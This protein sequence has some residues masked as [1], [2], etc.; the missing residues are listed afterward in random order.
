MNVTTDS[1]NPMKPTGPLFGLCLMY[2][3]PGIIERIGRDWDWFWLDGQHGQ[4]AGY[5]AMLAMVRAC[6]LVRRPAFVRVPGH[7]AGPIGL[8]LDMGADAVIIPQVDSVGQARAAIRAAKFPPLGNRSFGGRRPIDMGTRAYS[9]EANAR[10]RLICQIESPEALACVEEIAELPG[11]DGL[12]LGPDD[13]MLRCGQSLNAPLDMDRLAEAVSVVAKASRERGKLCV[14]VGSSPAMLSL[15]ESAGV[16]HIVAGSDA[17]F[18]A[19]GSKRVLEGVRQSS[20]CQ[21]GVY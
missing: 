12:F 13:L 14:C 15:F 18:L 10:T 3:A 4:I 2:P 7:E 11:V 8:A 9:E 21:T 19:E 20:S 1:D 6:N 16:T 17:G 5:D